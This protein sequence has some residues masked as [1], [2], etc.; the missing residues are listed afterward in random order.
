MGDARIIHFEVTGKDQK[1]L[2]SYYSDLFGWKL[3][4]DFP[5]GYGMTDPAQ[6]GLI[7]ALPYRTPGRPVWRQY[8]FNRIS[9]VPP[10]A[11]ANSVVWPTGKESR[12]VR[13]TPKTVASPARYSSRNDPLR[14]DIG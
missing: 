7:V 4:T 10:A 5:G 2:Q 8:G 1:A 11:I 12:G 14:Q 9:M 3:N 13:G 6:T